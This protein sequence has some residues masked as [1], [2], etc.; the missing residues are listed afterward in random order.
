MAN[1]EIGKNFVQTIMGIIRNELKITPQTI[2]A[3]VVRRNING[4]YTVKVPGSDET[5]TVNNQTPFVLEAG[6][7]VSLFLKNR[8]KLSDSFIIE[9]KGKSKHEEIE[10]PEAEEIKTKSETYEISGADAVTMVAGG[11]SSGVYSFEASYPSDEYNISVGINGATATS[12]Q[13][14]TWGLGK[15]CGDPTENKV[16]AKGTVP[17]VDIPVIVSWV[18]KEVEVN[19]LF[20]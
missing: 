18:K 10:I 13:I 6:D 16:Y 12:Q 5:I 11:W 20:S 17:T 14:N 1:N 9:A 15:M 2:P 19:G 8:D 4:T 3:S 7:V